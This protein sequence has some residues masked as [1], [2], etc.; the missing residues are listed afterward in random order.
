MN[1]KKKYEDMN[2]FLYEEMKMIDDLV[3]GIQSA[4]KWHLQTLTLPLP[5]GSLSR[6]GTMNA[7]ENHRF[8]N[9]ASPRKR[10][11]KDII[12]NIE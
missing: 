10:G 9:A 1:S 12:I 7:E 6:K 5:N 4:L 2:Q 8:F 3:F 11:R